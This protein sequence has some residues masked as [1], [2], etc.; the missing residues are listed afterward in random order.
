MQMSCLQHS[1]SN[2]VDIFSLG[3]IHI[4]IYGKMDV[5]EKHEVSII[6]LNSSVISAL[7]NDL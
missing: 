1:Y 7:I 4:E 5:I 6:I 3:L 2:N